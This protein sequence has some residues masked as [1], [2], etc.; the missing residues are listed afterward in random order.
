[1]DWELLAEL[2]DHK[3]KADRENSGPA[4]GPVPPG[5]LPGPENF[6]CENPEQDWIDDAVE[7]HRSNR[8]RP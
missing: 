7:A 2:V 5:R 1:M 3:R 4:Q 8:R 6:Q